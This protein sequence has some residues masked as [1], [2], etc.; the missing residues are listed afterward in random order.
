MYLFK[1]N[2]F[3]L[4]K[5][6]INLLLILSILFFYTNTYAEDKFVGFIESL[7][8]NAFKLIMKKKLKLNVV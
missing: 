4:I 6:K 5:I 3:N 8:G 2:L 1:N 7:E